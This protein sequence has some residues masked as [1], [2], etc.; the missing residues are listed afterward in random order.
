MGFFFAFIFIIKIKYKV[1]FLTST[2][3]KYT[4]PTKLTY[5]KYFDL[6]HSLHSSRLQLKQLPFK[7]ILC[8]S[9]SWE[10]KIRVS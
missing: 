4:L 6:P 5:V 1:V 3:N 8:F 7:G 10:Q 9:F 2:C